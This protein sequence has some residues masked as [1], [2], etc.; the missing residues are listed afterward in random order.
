M[1]T[2]SNLDDKI[3]LGLLNGNICILNSK[4]EIEEPE[5]NLNTNS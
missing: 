2:D 1:C 4:L 5:W 3:Y